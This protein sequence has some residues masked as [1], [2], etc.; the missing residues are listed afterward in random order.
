M[1]GCVLAEDDTGVQFPLLAPNF[2]VVGRMAM[3]H[4]SNVE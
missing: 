4:T 2:R 1:V 3:H